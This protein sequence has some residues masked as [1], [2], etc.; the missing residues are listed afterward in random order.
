M[1]ANMTRLLRVHTITEAAAKATILREMQVHTAIV[2]PAREDEE[3]NGRAAEQQEIQDTEEDQ[4]LGHADDVAAVG[5]G[6]GDGVEKPEKV[7]PAG[8]HGVVTADLDVVGGAVDAVVS[9]GARGGGLAEGGAACPEGLEGEEEVGGRAEGVESPLI[10]CGRV[11]GAQVGDDPDPGK[12]DIE[13]DGRPA[14]AADKSQSKDDDGEGNDPEDVFGEEDLVRQ[15]GAPVERCWDDGV[16]E[17][18]GHSEVGDSADE[19]SDG[20]EVMEYLLSMTRPEAEDVVDE[21]GEGEDGRDGPEPVG[22]SGGEMG[23]SSLRV[24][25]QGIVAALEE[26]H[27][28]DGNGDNS[29]L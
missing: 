9:G 6:K 19:K 5:H 27:G 22:P 1:T 2:P 21:E 8:E 29:M 24:D 3:G 11:G 13:Q 17:T 28:D 23:I 15:G 12:E 14:H 20:E 26:I 7:D 18:R 16:G 10:V 25:V 4:A